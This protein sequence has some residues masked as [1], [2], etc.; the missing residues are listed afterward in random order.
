MP[1]RNPIRNP[2]IGSFEDIGEN[3]VSQ[4]KQ[5]PKDVGQAAME[6]IGL[7]TG[8]GNKGNNPKQPPP[9]PG[10]SE[11]SYLKQLED[12]TKQQEEKKAIARK[13]LQEL[14]KPREKEPSVWERLQQEEE[15]KKAMAVE[16][17]KKAPQPIQLPSSGPR[18][19]PGIKN[20]A[21]TKSFGSEIGKNVRQD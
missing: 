11:Q 8:S 5:L 6:S 21:K 9:Q 12:Q 4:L 20:P 1:A 13:A 2:I 17:Q 15:Q 10:Q 3:I 7:S 18:K 16:Q 19:L 14:L